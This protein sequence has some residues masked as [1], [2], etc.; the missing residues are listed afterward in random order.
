MHFVLNEDEIPS[1]SAL[2]FHYLSFIIFFVFA[3]LGTIRLSKS[4][5]L[6]KK[7]ST[8]FV[9]IRNVNPISYFVL[10]IFSFY[11]IQYFK[12]I[13]FYNY[14]TFDFLYYFSYIGEALLVLTYA[15]LFALINITNKVNMHFLEKLTEKHDKIFINNKSQ[16]NKTKLVEKLGNLLNTTNNKE[17][18]QDL[19][20]F[21]L[22]VDFIL[23]NSHK[24]LIPIE[25]EIENLKRYL[26]FYDLRTKHPSFD[27]KINGSKQKIFIP[28]K[29]IITLVE[30][31]IKYGDGAFLIEIDILFTENFVIINVKNRINTKPII[32]SSNS[33]GL[34]N[35]RK[36][37]NLLLPEKHNLEINNDSGYY[38]VSLTIQN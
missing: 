15:V 1:W 7:D 33:I 9:T 36:R 10:G 30:N 18:N 38:S 25:S 12:N 31:A 35:L 29:S 32:L 17:L 3:Y 37:F 26:Y 24:G 23:N 20:N 5:E 13:Y 22:L 8:V 34:D 14:Y 11:L 21:I 4:L 28:H 19:N 6:N 16:Q 2:I 27:L